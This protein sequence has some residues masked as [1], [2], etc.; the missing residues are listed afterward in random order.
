M[1]SPAAVQRLPDWL[2]KRQVSLGLDLRGGSYLLYRVD[3]SSVVHDQLDNIVDA[4]RNE[5]LDRHIG[6]TGGLKVTDDHI[7]FG[8]RSPEHAEAVR[9]AVRK[10]A[11]ELQMTVGQDDEVTLAF[12][13]ATLDA[14]TADAVSRSI[15]IIRR[16]I[17]QAGVKEPTIERAG[18]DRIVVELPGVADPHRRRSAENSEV[19]TPMLKVTAKPLTGLVT[20]LLIIF[21]LR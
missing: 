11:P 13:P 10:V 7:V 19:N 18:A 15:E 16:R 6:R 12:S 17:D 14:P 9:A 20:R 1:F 5:L 8:L 4:L 2:P 21:W 3:M